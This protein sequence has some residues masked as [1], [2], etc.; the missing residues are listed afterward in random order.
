MNRLLSVAI[1]IQYIFLR[2]T[3]M[4]VGIMMVPSFLKLT[5][6]IEPLQR[7]ILKKI[8]RWSHQ[9]KVRILKGTNRHMAHPLGM[10]DKYNGSVRRT[11]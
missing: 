2:Q 8:P 5:V 6:L 7:R 4:A 3:E 9:K 1:G 10:K 11:V